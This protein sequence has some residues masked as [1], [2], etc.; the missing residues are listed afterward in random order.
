MNIYSLWK[1]VVIMP[2]LD[3]TGPSG[4]GHCR[5]N[6]HHGFWGWGAPC[7]W[8]K[9]SRKEALSEYRKALEEELEAI[10]KAETE[11]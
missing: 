10:K 5:R 1:E 6:P 9:T 3:G 11:E 2:Q 7:H 4:M 8:T